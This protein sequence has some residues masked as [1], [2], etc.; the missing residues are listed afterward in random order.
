[1]SAFWVYDGTTWRNI[2]TPWSYDGATWREITE[3]WVYDGALWRK[4]FESG[5][6]D[7]G[8][9]PT[10]DSVGNGWIDLGRFGNCGTSCADGRCTYSVSM[11]HTD[12]D[13]VCHNLDGYLSINGGS[14]LLRSLCTSRTCTNTTGCAA[15]GEFSCVLSA[16]GLN[17]STYQGRIIIE[18]T[19]DSSTICTITNSSSQTGNCDIV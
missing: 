15:G 18:E 12:C 19:F 1:M 16:C 17:T 3:A 13:D 2:T 5:P 6:P 8:D 14:Y 11:N 4:V 7:C 10:C 9:D